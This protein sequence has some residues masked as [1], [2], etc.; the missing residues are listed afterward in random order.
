MWPPKANLRT[1]I[2]SC[3][4]AL[5]SLAAI[6]ARAE[7]SSLTNNLELIPE[8]Q[9]LW[10]ESFL[11]DK[12]VVLRTGVGYKDNVLLA[13]SG[14]KGSGFVTSGLDLTIFRLPLDGWEFSLTMVGDD[15]RYFRRPGGLSGEDLFI[16]SALLQRYFS[17]GW[18]VGLEL[19]YSYVDQVLQ[20]LLNAGGIQAIEAKGNSFGIRPFVRHDFS[21]NW[22]VQLEA[23]LARDWWQAPLDASWKWG[24]Q[25]VLGMSYGRHSQVSIEGGALHIP[26]DRW[27]ARDASGN[28]LT[29]K[30]LAVWREVAE[31]KWEHHLDAKQHWSSIARLGFTHAADNGG[32]YYNYDRYHASEELKF[33]TKDWEIK[34]SATFSYFDFPVQM[35][36]PSPA[37]TLRLDTVQTS[38]RVERRIYKSLRCF[39]V[40]EHEQTTSDDQASEYRYNVGMAGVSWEF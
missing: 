1:I 4:V 23:P 32:G 16:S 35:V 9:N 11:W 34:G 7:S 14:A 22:W 30:R 6:T 19:R 8:D 18:R 12:D 38:V 2:S 29:G 5:L 26:H 40:Y 27:L 37:P 28:E 24:G 17:Q 31:L 10:K 36:G 3:C 33:R 21:T 13:P 20:E 25:A 39:A 15:V